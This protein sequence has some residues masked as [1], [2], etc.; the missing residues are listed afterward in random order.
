MAKSFRNVCLLA[1]AVIAL[2]AI[3]AEGDSQQLVF[4]SQSWTLDG[5]TNV[6][7]FRGPKITQGDLGIE[8]DEAIA[9]GI[10]FEQQ[11]E[12]RFTGHVRIQLKGAL[13]TADSAVFTFA[14]KRLARGEL[15]GSATFED[16][17]R[18]EGKQAVRGGADKV[19]YDE[20]ART[21]R[22]SENAW[23]H[24]DQYEMQGCDLIYNLNGE[25]VSSGSPNC[26]QPFRIR[27]LSQQDGNAA[28]TDA[29]Q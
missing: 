7:H 29:P 26:P 13:I 8:A 24:K 19:L 28:T 12:W 14:D 10:E 3:A 20:K 15:T 16:T 25:G 4:E 18:V 6:I 27:V 22:L 23:V 2:C 9:T 1:F 5:K 17:E 21:L 11:S